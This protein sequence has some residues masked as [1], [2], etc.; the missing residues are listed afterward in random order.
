MENLVLV[1]GSSINEARKEIEKNA[2]SGKKIVLAAGDDEVNRKMLESAKVDYILGLENGIRK[3]KLKQR[4]SG[5][6]Q[7][8]AKIAHENNVALGIDFSEISKLKDKEFSMYAGRL[9]QNIKLCNKYKVKMVLFNYSGKNRHD[10]MAFLL[11]LG[12]STIMAKYA[13]ENRVGLG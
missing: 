13:V 11:S 4:D 1:K 7:V 3:D 8:L 5:F 6:N 2:K 9:M 12:M 10:L